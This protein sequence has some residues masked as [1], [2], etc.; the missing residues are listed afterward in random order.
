MILSGGVIAEAEAGRR[1]AGFLMVEVFSELRRFAGARFF[2]QWV[3]PRP[4]V[5]A[6][7]RVGA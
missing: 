2:Q 6:P 4:T 7:P 3:R 1:R 5:Y